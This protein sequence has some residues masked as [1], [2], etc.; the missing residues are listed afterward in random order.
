VGQYC[1]EI[2]IPFSFFFLTTGFSSLNDVCQAFAGGAISAQQQKR[3]SARHAINSNALDG[4]Y[5]RT[6]GQGR[7]A[8]EI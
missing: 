8:W 6:Q 7:A 2:K 1:S 5:E 4:H 3:Q